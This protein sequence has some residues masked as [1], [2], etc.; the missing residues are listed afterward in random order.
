M[1]G[2]SGSAHS[3]LACDE[4]HFRGKECERMSNV[5]HLV[6]NLNRPACE[7]PRDSFSLTTRSPENA[8]RRGLG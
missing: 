6:A 4:L 5:D 8:V 3:D 7:G 2:Y 1:A